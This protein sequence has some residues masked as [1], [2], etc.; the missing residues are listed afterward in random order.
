MVPKINQDSF[1]VQK[2]YPKETRAFNWMF[3]VFDGHGPNGDIISQEAAKV[4]P[5]LLEAKLQKLCMK[6]SQQI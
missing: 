4:L 5:N 1:A 6:Y 3:E 2:G